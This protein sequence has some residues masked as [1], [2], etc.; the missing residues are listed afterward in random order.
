M[1]SLQ[2]QGYA[3]RGFHSLGK[4]M[5]QVSASP[6]TGQ[7]SSHPTLVL[8]ARWHPCRVGLP[9]RETEALAMEMAG[10]EIGL[11]TPSLLRGWFVLL[12]TPDHAHST[13]R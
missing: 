12:I 5:K 8:E 7:E 6:H 1:V 3:G 2:L 9:P 11:P 13:S 10:P 4:E